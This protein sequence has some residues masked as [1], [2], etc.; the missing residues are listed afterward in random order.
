MKKLLSLTFVFSFIFISCSTEESSEMVTSQKD[1]TL[2][3]KTKEDPKN[4]SP[5]NTANPYDQTGQLYYKILDAYYANPTATTT[6]TTIS[7]IEELAN[8]FPEFL[9][10]Q[11]NPYTSIQLANINALL[12]SELSFTNCTTL[13]SVSKSN[14]N[15]LISNLNIM[16]DNDDSAFE[17][18]SY[19]IAFEASIMSNS[20]ISTTDSEQILVSTSIIRNNNYVHRRKKNRR[21]DIHHG[22]IAASDGQNES[23]AKAAT[24]AATIDVLENNE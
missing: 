18:N 19:I 7:K 17:I 20:S 15:T 11:E 21:W 23:Y 24:S 13:S 6:A 10:M 8:T 4:W 5:N 22:I 1:E 3:L 9:T 16:S 2:S 14:L 12:N